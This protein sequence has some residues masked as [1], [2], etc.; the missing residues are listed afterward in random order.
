[1]VALPEIRRQLQRSFVAR[2]AL[3]AFV[4]GLALAERGRKA[5]NTA[6]VTRGLAEVQ[7]AAGSLVQY[8]DQPEFRGALARPDAAPAVLISR[9]LAKQAAARPADELRG[10]RDLAVG[11]A[12]TNTATQ[13]R[14]VGYAHAEY[15]ART[16]GAVRSR[17]FAE[18]QRLRQIRENVLLAVA[19]GPA[20]V[21]LA[22]ADL[23]LIPASLGDLSDVLGLEELRRQAAEE[24]ERF[25]VRVSIGTGVVLGTAVVAAVVWRRL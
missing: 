17:E 10:A 12:S 1:M 11:D 7:K 16:I 6:D 13:E 14:P 4:G 9:L 15:L 21:V 3:G 8:L 18:I 19:F 22:A 25:W 2:E 5:K 24:W 23:G 20:G